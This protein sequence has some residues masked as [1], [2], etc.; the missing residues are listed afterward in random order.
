MAKKKPRVIVKDHGLIDMF[1]RARQIKLAT[2]KVG[3][4]DGPER[5]DGSGMTNAEIAAILELGNPD[6]NQAPRP[7]IGPVF[8]EQREAM[9]EMGQ[10]LMGAVLFDGMDIAVA[11]GRIGLFLATK[12]KLKITSGDGVPPPNL[13]STLKA[14]APKTKTWIDSGKVLGAFTWKVVLGGQKK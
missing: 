10:Q 12:M 1:K 13:P 7:V 4:L 3:V 9:R 2:V 5:S 11:L 6:N 14:K 8:D